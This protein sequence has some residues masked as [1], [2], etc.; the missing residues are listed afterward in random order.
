MFFRTNCNLLF[1]HT[2]ILFTTSDFSH[3]LVLQ[4]RSIPRSKELGQFKMFYLYNLEAVLFFNISSFPVFD[5]YIVICNESPSLSNDKYF[6]IAYCFFGVNIC[7][8]IIGTFISKYKAI[9]VIYYAAQRQAL[10]RSND[11]ILCQSQVP[12]EFSSL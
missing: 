8:T 2:H 12:T 3:L 4:P 10:Q 1:H 9:I 7:H 11:H 5:L 6:N